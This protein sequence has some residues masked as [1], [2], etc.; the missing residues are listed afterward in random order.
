MS[1]VP[2]VSVGGEVGAAWKV[3]SVAI[4]LAVGVIVGAALW[5]VRVRRYQ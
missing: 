4:I 3:A 2:T 1:V 5:I